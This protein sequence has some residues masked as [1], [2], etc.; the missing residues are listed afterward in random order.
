MN[1]TG[2]K[3]KELEY[4]AI[5][6]M[7]KI[8]SPHSNFLTPDEYKEIQV[9]TKGEF[10]GVSIEIGIKKKILT[11]VTPYRGFTSIHSRIKAIRNTQNK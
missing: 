5:K 4:A 2:V 7:V 10:G 1:T 6:K 3:P 8:T 11:I 9:E